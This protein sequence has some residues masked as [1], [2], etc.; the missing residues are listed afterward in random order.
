MKVYLIGYMCCG[1]STL[2]KKL[3]KRLNY[4]FLD[5]DQLFEETYKI[6]IPNFFE[7]YGEKAF[8][9]L[10]QEIL[11][12][13]ANIYDAVIA[14]GG[15]TPCFGD[16]MAWI[17]KNGLSVYLKQKDCFIIDRLKKT[18]KQRPLVKNIPENEIA[19]YVCNAIQQ[20]EVYYNE[21]NIILND[22]EIDLSSIVLSINDV[23]M[24]NKT[25]LSTKFKS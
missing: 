11:Y 20:R 4:N 9:S 19:A 6:S 22:T 14:T 17:N 7:K 24:H 12:S 15:G 5:L 21:S 23:I 8:R 1:K 16:N 2:G 10:E 18:K 25:T 13:T 3:A